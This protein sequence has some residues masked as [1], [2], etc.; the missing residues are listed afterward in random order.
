MLN[1]KTK[2]AIL[3]LSCGSIHPRDGQSNRIF[4]ALKDFL[5]GTVRPDRVVA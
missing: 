3:K 2:I 1:V 5:G 4:L